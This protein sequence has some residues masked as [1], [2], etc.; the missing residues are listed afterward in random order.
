MYKFGYLH[1][2]SKS[3][4][5]LILCYLTYMNNSTVGTHTQKLLKVTSSSLHARFTPAFN[6]DP[7]INQLS[8]LVPNVCCHYHTVAHQVATILY[9]CSIKISLFHP[10][11][12]KWNELRSREDG[13]QTTGFPQHL[14]NGCSTNC[15][16]GMK[17]TVLYPHTIIKC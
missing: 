12:K 6:G 7:G 2:I 16:L 15:A 3:F 5:F 10:H 9:F 1:L 11:K 17:S 4:S 14:D 13:D 8:R